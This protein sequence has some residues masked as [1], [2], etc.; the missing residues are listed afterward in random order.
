MDSLTKP[1]VFTNA[2]CV[3]CNRCIAVCSSMG[4]CIATKADEN[5]KSHILVDPT[6]CIACGAC[7]DACEHNAREYTDDTEAFFEA[8][9]AGEQISVLIAPAFRANYPDEYGRVLGGLK[10]LGVKRFIN[11]A[12]GA[13]I[14]TWGYVN[15]IKNYGFLGGISQP[16]PAVVNYIEKYQPQL[17]PSLFPVQSPLMCAAI[18][19]RKEMGITDK[20]AFI[21]PCIAKKFEIT[22]PVNKGLVSYNVTFDHLMRYVHQHYVTGLPC[23]DEVEYGMGVLYPMPG[24]LAANIRWLL[25]DDG[26]I[27]QIEGEKHLYRFLRSN[28][29]HIAEGET[30]FMFIDALNCD[31]GC[32]CGT[33]TDPVISHTETAL[34]NL[35][36]IRESIKKEHPGSAWSRNA[37][38]QERL[39]AL[40]KQFANLDLKDYIR[41]YTDRSESCK[42]KLPSADELDAIFV[43][44]KKYAPVSRNINCGSCGYESCREMATAIFNGFNYKEN[45]VYF[46]KEEAA[47]EHRQLKYQSEHDGLLDI[48]NRRAATAVL[49]KQLT[50]DT[51]YSIII[52]DIDGFKS[53]NETYGY[54]QTDTILRFLGVKMKMLAT[55]YKLLLARYGGDEFLFAA[56]GVHLDE[57]NPVMREIMH[58]FAEPVPVGEERIRISVCAGI[59]NSDGVTAPDQHVINAENAMFVAK[60]RKRN[61]VFVYS[62]DLKKQALEETRIKEKLMEAFEN[63]GFY[64][65]YQP[66]INSRT[67]KVSGY[68][69]LVRMK[70]PGLYPGQFIPVAEKNGWIWRIG[71]ITTELTIKQLAAW[72]KEGHE[73]HPV[74]INFSSNQLSD[75]GYMDFLENLLAKYDVPS[76]F[77]EMEITE[78]IFLKKSAQADELFRRL[79]DL[80]IRLLMD[81]FGTGYS[82]LAYLTYIPVDV[83]KLDKSLVDTYLVDGK[84]S[85]IRNVIRLVHDLDKEMLIEGVEENW[86]Y[87]RLCEF[88]ADTIQGYYFSKPIPADEAIVFTVPEPPQA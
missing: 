85:F 17:I 45:C 65:V 7:F 82:S 47:E 71:R 34:Y 16:C 81:D 54:A 13:D 15:Y 36:A 14:S 49:E 42:V 43:E 12:F 55:R 87:K 58:I 63:D 39:E 6:R 80:N 1:L 27:R 18:Y 88:N 73:L 60:A 22:D 57:T 40:N 70:A 29:A 25:G 61:S 21:S 76:R 84:D 79:K 32:L 86:Q 68:E 33:A 56:K 24:G 67:R 77:V 69:A 3:G 74:S 41:T 72:R 46:L 20:F 10:A 35:L 38:P 31:N 59:S 2:K 28:A 11:V 9:K 5:G 53:L 78:G 64:M 62:D 30:P 4:A 19:A 50:L 23:T 26:F 52:V 75:T 44:M 37:T 83:I 51:K 8:L 66:Q 48:L